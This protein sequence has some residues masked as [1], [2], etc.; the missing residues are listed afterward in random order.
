MKKPSVSLLSTKTHL[1]SIGLLS[2]KPYSVVTD[3]YA[4]MHRGNIDNIHIP[5]SDVY[6]VR[7]AL[8]KIK[9]DEKKAAP[10]PLEVLAKMAELR[11]KA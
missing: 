11:R 6:F 3:V 10:I 9:A 2:S 1:E 8:E 5:H 4:A 7:T